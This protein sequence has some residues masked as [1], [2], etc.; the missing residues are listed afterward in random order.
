[1][2]GVQDSA[3][4]GRCV[5]HVDVDAFYAQCEEIRNPALR[6]RPL[7][8]LA[9]QATSKLVMLIAHRAHVDLALPEITGI[10]QKYLLVTSNYPARRCG[11]TKLMGITEAQQKCPDLVLVSG[12]DL[13]PYRQPLALSVS[14]QAAALDMSLL[15]D[16]WS[17]TKGIYA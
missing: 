3:D 17:E 16:P 7:G 15:P 8:E 11:V 14:H 1:M 4:T 5:V 2:A 13:T 9:K 10:T 6:E 12:E